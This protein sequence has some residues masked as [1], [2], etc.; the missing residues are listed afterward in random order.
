MAILV[1]FMTFG[2]GNGGEKDGKGEERREKQNVRGT[3]RYPAEGSEK[4]RVKECGRR[5]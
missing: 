1:P 5:L 3:G 4:K 2:S